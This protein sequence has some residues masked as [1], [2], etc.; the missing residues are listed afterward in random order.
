MR[1]LFLPEFNTYN[2]NEIL[3]FCK[4]AL[5]PLLNTNISVKF[6]KH[7]KNCLHH[8][9]SVSALEDFFKFQC[10]FVFYWIFDLFRN[11][12]NLFP[13]ILQCYVPKSGKYY[14][15]LYIVNVK[16][17]KSVGLNFNWVN[18]DSV[19]MIFLVIH[20]T[21]R[22]EICLENLPWKAKRY[23]ISHNFKLSI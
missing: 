5:D 23:F 15:S 8:L 3:P 7:L 10:F 21:E 22:C 20:A 18:F 1:R 19:T 11:Q 9:I 4:M 12:S 13:N 14:K 17:D 16:V 6:Q 2:V